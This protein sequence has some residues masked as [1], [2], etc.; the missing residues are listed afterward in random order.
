MDRL[1]GMAVFARVAEAGS[2]SVAAKVCGLSATM[3][4]NHIQNLERRLGTKLI[5]RT[6]RRQSLTEVGQSFLADCLD[7]LA[8]VETAKQ[9]ARQ[10]HSRP[11]GRLRISATTSF[12]THIVTPLIRD[13]LRLYPDVE[14][15]LRPTD[16]IVD[17]AEEGIEAAFRFADLPDSRLVARTL[18]PRFRRVCASPD[19]VARHGAPATPADLVRHN[20]LLFSDGAPRNRWQFAGVP[21]VE[22]SGRF[23][24]D[25]RHFAFAKLCIGTERE[26]SLSGWVRPSSAAGGLR[27]A[28]QRKRGN[29]RRRGLHIPQCWQLTAVPAF[30]PER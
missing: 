28:I 16:R 17:L 1:E 19:Y 22:V 14:V 24:A 30:A 15:D 18:R 5:H 11:T 9:A 4:A 26:I 21:P 27:S 20:C 8:R 12:G 3:V 25:T 13:C 10:R 29:R 7:V 23:V 6:T 2:F